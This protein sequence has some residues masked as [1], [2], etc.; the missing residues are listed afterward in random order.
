MWI[1]AGTSALLLFVMLFLFIPCFV[2]NTRVWNQLHDVRGPFPLHVQV[3]L[4]IRIFATRFSCSVLGCLG[5]LPREGG[6]CV[7]SG[8]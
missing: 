5:L 8:L 6:I 2:A 4:G 1:L 7:W 3:Y